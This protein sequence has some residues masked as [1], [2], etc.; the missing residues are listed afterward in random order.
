MKKKRIRWSASSSPDVVSYRLYWANKGTVG[1]GSDFVDIRHKREITL[2]DE[3]PSFQKTGGLIEL[4]ITALSFDGNESDMVRFTVTLEPA[5]PHVPKLLV[6]P[7]SE[8]WEAPKNTPILVDDLNHWVIRA[9]PPLSSGEPGRGH[10][11]FIDSHHVDEM[12]RRG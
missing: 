6:R 5:V 12:R 7:A 3:I 11:Y 1:Y 8:G 4:G 10:D 9:V 2:P